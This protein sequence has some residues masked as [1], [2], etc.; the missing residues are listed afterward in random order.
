VEHAG[1]GNAFS[2]KRSRKRFAASSRFKFKE[3]AGRRLRETSQCRDT[4]RVDE[5]ENGNKR[6]RESGNRKK[7]ERVHIE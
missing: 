4:A 3:V 2:K 7:I 5:L 6:K 1:K